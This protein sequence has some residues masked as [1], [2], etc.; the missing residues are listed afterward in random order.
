M[1]AH[2]PDV[3]VLPED[4]DELLRA[5][6]GLERLLH[7]HPEGF[8]RFGVDVLRLPSNDELQ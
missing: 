1:D 8:L 7:P 6:E 5:L 2:T 3:L 4:S